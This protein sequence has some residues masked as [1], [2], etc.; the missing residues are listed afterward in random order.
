MFGLVSS[1]IFARVPGSLRFRLM[2]TVSEQLPPPPPKTLVPKR[3]MPLYVPVLLFALTAALGKSMQQRQELK[4]H[5]EYV[6]LLRNRQ[7]IFL[8]LLDEGPDSIVARLDERMK[9]NPLVIKKRAMTFDD[10]K[11]E[12]QLLLNEIREE[13][14][15]NQR[16]AAEVQAEQETVGTPLKNHLY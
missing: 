15:P 4:V 13:N 14:H 9:K 16:R 2:S 3:K 8:H 1:R 11:N 5:T 10:M 7:A 12:L 6:T